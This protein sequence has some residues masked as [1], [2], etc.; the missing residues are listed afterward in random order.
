MLSLRRDIASAQNRFQRAGQALFLSSGNLLQA[1]D[2]GNVRVFAELD[3]R[4]RRVYKLIVV[5]TEENRL[6]RDF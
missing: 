6:K 1:H 2:R 4:P 5:E 3:F